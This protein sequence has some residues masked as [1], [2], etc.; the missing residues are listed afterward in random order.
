MPDDFQS[1]AQRL[2]DLRDSDNLASMEDPA[3]GAYRFVAE[4]DARAQ[5][6]LIIAREPVAVAR[7]F[8]VDEFCSA[9]PASRLLAGRPAAHAD[10]GA[11]ICV[12]HGVGA[13]EIEAAIAR[14]A[15]PCVDSVGRATRAGTGCGSCR[16][17]IH[18]LVKAALAERITAP[19][20]AG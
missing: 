9:E 8:L 16:P 1:F 19:A 12:C 14:D 18:R 6:L 7:D 13:K 10:R 4:R 11:A 20:R 3:R 17:E 15:S 2:L 5:A